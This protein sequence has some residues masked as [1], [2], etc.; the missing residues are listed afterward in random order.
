MSP[1]PPGVAAGACFFFTV[2]TTRQHAVL[3]DE[4]VRVALR[5]AIVAVR[6]A[7]PFRIEGWVLLPDRMHA[8]W[9]LP[10]GDADHGARWREIKRRVTRLV[11]AHYLRADGRPACGRDALWQLR[12]EQRR[13][14][15]AEELAR[16]LD[17]LHYSPVR[18]GWAA[19]VRDWPYSSFH[20]HVSGGRYPPDWME[21]QVG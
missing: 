3:T 12:Y 21:G 18:H 9:T 4:M 14:A 1:L 16:H 7:R 8:I 5:R 6:A 19:R 17:F 13:V 20:R 2:A 10:A 11:G 15:G